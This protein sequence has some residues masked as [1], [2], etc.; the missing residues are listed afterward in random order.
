MLG[1]KPSG[2]DDESETSHSE[3]QAGAEDAA[4]AFADA[5]QAKDAKRIVRAFCALSTLCGHLDELADAG[6]VD[7]AEEE[8]AESEGE[9]A[10]EEE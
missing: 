6:E 8:A 1:G 3:A 4:H 10:A 9:E 2:G 5:V 7:D